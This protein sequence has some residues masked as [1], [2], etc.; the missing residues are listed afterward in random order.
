[1]QTIAHVLCPVDVSEAA[2]Q[3]LRYAAALSSLLGSDLKIL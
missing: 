1:M 3:S 2:V